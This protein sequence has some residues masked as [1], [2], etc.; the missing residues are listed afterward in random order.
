MVFMEFIIKC[1]YM[2]N[3]IYC[4]FLFISFIS[5]NEN[6][7]SAKQSNIPSDSILDSF[8]NAFIKQD[9]N[10]FLYKLNE[11]AISIKDPSIKYVPD[12]VQ[13]PYP[14]GDVPSNTGVCTDVIIRAYRKLGTDLQQLVHEDMKANFNKY[15]KIWGRKTPDENIDHRRVPN[16]MTFFKR[17]GESL[18][19]SNN[20]RDY[21]P[22]SIITWNLSGGLTHIGIVVNIASTDGKR[23]LIMHNI[24][25]GQIIEDCL[26]KY[27]ITG[28]F[29][30]IPH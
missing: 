16:L 1:L 19:I 6:A 11:A 30:F 12:Y 25:S 2:K 7:I 15:P 10:S 22:G 28:H 23:P 29:H 27:E 24:G 18:P 14:N 26:L 8:N 21:K 13:I 9:T 5:C 17:K 20:G 4:S 3:I